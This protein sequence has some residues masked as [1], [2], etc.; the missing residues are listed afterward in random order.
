M[1]FIG[2]YIV[3][4]DHHITDFFNSKLLRPRQRLGRDLRTVQ[5]KVDGLLRLIP[6]HKMVVARGQLKVYRA[7]SKFLCVPLHR[8]Q[9]RDAKTGSLI[10]HKTRYPEH[11]E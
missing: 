6:M 5:E 3:M 4:L 1:V 2:N 7:I 8:P 11:R 9:C 10:T